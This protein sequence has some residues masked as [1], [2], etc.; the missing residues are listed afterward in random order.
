MFD[1]LLYTSLVVFFLGLIYRISTW[2]TKKIGILGKDVSTV[3]RLQAA[4]RGIAGVVFSSKILALLETVVLDF[5]LQRR[6]LKESITR[7]LAHMLIFY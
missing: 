4:L 6:I 5:F 7:W 2:F 3:Q 1:Y